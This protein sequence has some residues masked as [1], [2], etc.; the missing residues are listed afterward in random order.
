MVMFIVT[1]K[2]GRSVKPYILN[3][4]QLK[5]TWKLSSVDDDDIPLEDFVDMSVD[6]DIWETSSI[7]IQ[8]VW[9]T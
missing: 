2:S 4:E 9:T 5:R 6:G 3:A 1:D 8:C 7:K